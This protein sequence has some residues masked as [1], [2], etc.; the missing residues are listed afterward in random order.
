MRTINRLEISDRS[1]SAS[2]RAH[3]R[4]L[5]SRVT[6]NVGLIKFDIIMLGDHLPDPHTGQYNETQAERFPLWADLVVRADQ[7]GFHAAWFGEHHCSNYIISSPQ[8]LLAAVAARTFRIRLGTAVSLLPNSDPVRIAEEFATLDLLSGG[9]AEIGFGGGITEHTFRLF[10]QE[11]KDGAEMASENLK[12]LLDLWNK[13]N[14]E[15]TGRFRP[16]IRD[17]RLEPRTFSG[18][19]L[20]VNRATATS[21]ATARE[22]GRAGFRFML[23][24]NA[25]GFAAARSLAEAYRASYLEAGH[26]P[27]GMSVAAPAYVYVQPNGESA[28][29]FWQ[30]YIANYRAFVKKVTDDK[31]ASIGMRAAFSNITPEMLATREVDFV[32]SPREVAAKVIRADAEIGGLDRLMC[33]FDCGGLSR[34]HTFESLELFCSEVLPMLQ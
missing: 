5:P 14:I 10:G 33:Y 8:M 13:E 16:P 25:R 2:C 19:S 34:A 30:P 22:A 4:L 7:L 27:V 23:M 11:V 1:L 29:S 15:W 20:P 9:R 18:K 12:L 17:S 32:G 3:R 21:I 31:G 24:T 6:I 28:R 26:D